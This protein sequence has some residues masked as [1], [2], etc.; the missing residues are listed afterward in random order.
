MLIAFQ[1]RVVGVIRGHHLVHESASI[2][3]AIVQQRLHPL[4]DFGANEDIRLVRLRVPGSGPRVLQLPPLRLASVSSP[5]PSRRRSTRGYMRPYSPKSRTSLHVSPPSDESH[6]I[7]RSI[8]SSP[9]ATGRPSFIGC[10]GLGGPQRIQ[11]S[12]LPFFVK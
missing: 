4:E 12:S 2:R 8:E 10:I 11:C 9:W 1:I 5:R 6:H 3:Q 7:V